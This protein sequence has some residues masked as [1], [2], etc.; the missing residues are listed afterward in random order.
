M[1]LTRLEI[2]LYGGGGGTVPWNVVISASDYFNILYPGE[3]IVFLFTICYMTTNFVGLI[4]VLNFGTQYSFQSRIVPG[5]I[6]YCICMLIIPYVEVKGWS[7]TIAGILGACDSV[8]QGSLFGL[9]GLFSPRY[10]SGFMAGQGVA[11]LSV[12]LLRLFAKGVFPNDDQ[13]IRH[14]GYLYFTLSVVVIVIAVIAYLR[15][16]QKSPVTKHYLSKASAADIKSA[17][18][19]FVT[20]PM[21]EHDAR[22]APKD[23][24]HLSGN[25]S[26]A[27]NGGGGGAAADNGVSL[28]T[29]LP[30]IWQM[31][32]VVFLIFF[33]TLSLFPG[34]TSELTSVKASLNDG[35]WFGIIMIGLF[36]AG[37]LIGRTIPNWPRFII[38]N[39]LVITVLAVLRVVFLPLFIAAARHDTIFTNDF[40]PVLI[41]I[42]FAISN[43]YLGT[44]AMMAAVDKVTAKEKELT[45]TGMVF[46]LTI[47]LTSG[48]WTGYIL[49]TVLHL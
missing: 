48:V 37:D 14:S 34:I 40:Y 11:G 28:R 21:S 23:V 36:D 19:R 12:A 32:F 25:E 24:A 10:V 43:G 46:F 18:S 17:F 16:L 4:I 9:V 3:S 1:R 41:M 15:V 31:A 7:L 29:I 38:R 13:G 8:V 22:R 2:I 44:V 20:V 26:P 35:E 33:V 47:G 45:G 30:Q 42:G 39:E 49:N 5:F 27:I 6:V